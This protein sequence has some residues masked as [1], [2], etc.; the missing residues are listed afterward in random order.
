MSGLGQTPASPSRGRSAGP[1]GTR[2]FSADELRRHASETGLVLAG[3]ASVDQPVL[4]RVGA[5]ESRQRF[6]L[7]KGRQTLGRQG[8]NHIVIDDLSVSSSHAW[9]MN[10]Q[11]H[12]LIMNTLSTNGTFV[13]GRRVHEATLKHG[14]RIQLG[15]AEFLFLTREPRSRSTVRWAWITAGTLLVALGALAWWLH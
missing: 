12:Y 10:Q 8:N 7:R 5:D 2:L 14:D 1:Q 13:N 4:E 6:V 15:Q 9:I 11:G 3:R